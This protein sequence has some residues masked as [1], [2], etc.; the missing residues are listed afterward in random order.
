MM[1]WERQQNFPQF[2]WWFFMFLFYWCVCVRVCVNVYFTDVCFFICVLKVGSPKFNWLSI[3]MSLTTISS[4]EN[5]IYFQGFKYHFYEVNYRIFLFSF[6][7]TTDLQFQY[8]MY[9]FIYK[10]TKL[11]IPA[12][13]FSFLL[14]SSV[15]NL[16]TYLLYFCLQH[17]FLGG[18]GFCILFILT[19][20]LPI[21]SLILSP[22]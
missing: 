15:R 21:Q 8:Q 2:P 6:N 4:L 14:F 17:F 12:T 20:F 10:K 7:L 18:G 9:I 13:V 19:V 11:N 16:W 22:T 1:I 5:S 3:L